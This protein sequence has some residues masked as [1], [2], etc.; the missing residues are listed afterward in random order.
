MCTYN[1]TKEVKLTIL[2]S[3]N[4]F[5][6]GCCM[7]GNLDMFEIKSVQVIQSPCF[8]GILYSE[9]HLSDKWE[10]FKFILFLWFYFLCFHVGFL[11]LAFISV[12]CIGSVYS[13]GCKHGQQ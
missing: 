6:F 7:A 9:Q 12:T 5:Q 2:S 13:L 3:L 10:S 8:F 1:W 11:F 4:A